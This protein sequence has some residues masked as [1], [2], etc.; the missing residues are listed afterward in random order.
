M[1]DPKKHRKRNEL[2]AVQA[3]GTLVRRHTGLVSINNFTGM[4][5][6]D[7]RDPSARNTATFRR[8]RSCRR[9]VLFQGGW[10]A[11]RSRRRTRSNEDHPRGCGAALAGS[12]CSA[13]SP[14][15]ASYGYEERQARRS[16]P[17]RQR[18]QL[19]LRT[20]RER[21]QSAAERR[22]IWLAR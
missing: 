3:A 20:G 17:G 13:D 14:V 6:Y 22:R 4:P 21:I 8:R 18:R 10:H 2:C 12:T 5:R 9:P 7:A 16:S 11:A 15:G 1:S 19:S